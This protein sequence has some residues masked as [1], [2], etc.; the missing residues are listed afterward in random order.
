MKKFETVDEYI[1]SFPPEVQT[2]LETIRKT[3]QKEVPKATEAISYQ[4]PAFNLNGRYLI[5][6]SAWKKHTSLYPF[7]AEMEKLLPKTP[8]YK[9]SGKGTIQFPL[10]QPLPLL[11]IK[12]IVKFKVKEN[13]KRI[14]K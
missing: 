4:I 10:D 8:K 6:Y 13:L 1:K 5:Y 3:I 9:T 11:L 2:I 12:K 14:K 7:T